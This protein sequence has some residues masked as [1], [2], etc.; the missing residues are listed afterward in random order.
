M[1]MTDPSSPVEDVSTPKSALWRWLVPVVVLA[2]LA[3]AAWLGWSRS[4]SPRGP[5]SSGPIAANDLQG[6]WAWLG[7]ENCQDFFRTISFAGDRIYTRDDGQGLIDVRGA[8]YALMPAAREPTVAVKY[9]LGGNAYEA[10]YRFISRAQIA[11]VDDLKN[12]ARNDAIDRGRGRTLVRC[13]NADPMPE[14]GSEVRAFD[15]SPPAP[16]PQ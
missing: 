16:Q 3:A 12:G 4:Q 1:N 14:I 10:H 7:P 9:A 15:D 8:S 11:L 5:N 6:T 2:V 13:A